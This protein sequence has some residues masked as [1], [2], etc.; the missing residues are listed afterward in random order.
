MHKLCRQLFLLKKYYC[1]S[2]LNTC[3]NT[4]VINTEEHMKP[5]L[6]EKELLFWNVVNLA[7]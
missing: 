1:I 7:E 6:L 4:I 3:F 5:D 2:R